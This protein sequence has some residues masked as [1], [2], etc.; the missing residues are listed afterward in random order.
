[1]VKVPEWK[2]EAFNWLAAE[3]WTPDYLLVD[4]SVEGKRYCKVCDGWVSRE[5]EK[6][7]VASHRQQWRDMKKKRDAE[8][9]RAREEGKK[10]A[11]A[12]RKRLREFEQRG[13]E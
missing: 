6:K 5:D 10:R 7:H 12:E 3:R 4:Y 9:K 8:A 2:L 11:A 1:V 13:N